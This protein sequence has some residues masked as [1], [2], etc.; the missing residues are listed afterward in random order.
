MTMTKA[1]GHFSF[2]LV[3]T[4]RMIL[5][6]TPRRSSRLIPGLRGTPAVTTTT[7][8][9]ETSSYLLVP[10]MRASTIHAFFETAARYPA[11]PAIRHRAGSGKWASLRWA[12]YAQEVRRVARG[13]VA[14]GVGPGDRV[15]ICGPN[16]LEWL[17]AD[18]GA[19]AA[20]AV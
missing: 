5:M 8:A 2:T 10:T 3:A 12:D 6:F 7:S 18:F 1:E 16:R 15:A 9:P 19:L 4:S 17:L 13:L 14:L 11:G 20:G